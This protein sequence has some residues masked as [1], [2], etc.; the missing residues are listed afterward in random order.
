MTVKLLVT[1]LDDKILFP[2]TAH[3]TFIKFYKMQ[4]RV[5]FTKSC[6]CS[7][8]FQD[9]AGNFKS[10][11]DLSCTFH[12]NGKNVFLSMKFQGF[13]TFWLS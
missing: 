11:F 7:D 12:L 9:N 6:T 5:F 10:K 13:F 3:L 2:N 4:D 8:D 1:I